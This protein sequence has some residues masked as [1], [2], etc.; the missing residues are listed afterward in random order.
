MFKVTALEVS[1]VVILEVSVKSENAKTNP[2]NV[3]I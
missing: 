3:E 1:A 2:L